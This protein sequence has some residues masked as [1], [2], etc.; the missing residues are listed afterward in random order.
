MEK[1]CKL[2][3]IDDELIAAKT[4]DGRCLFLM[5][6]RFLPGDDGKTV[7]LPVKVKDVTSMLMQAERGGFECPLMKK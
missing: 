2:F 5:S 4:D 6:A 1:E 3:I 7:E